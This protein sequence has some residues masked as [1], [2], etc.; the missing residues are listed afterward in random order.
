MV[1]GFRTKSF[2]YPFPTIIFSKGGKNIGISTYILIHL[3]RKIYNKRHGYVKLME[4]DLKDCIE[5][6]RPQNVVVSAVLCF[7]E[8]MV[9]TF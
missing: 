5:C 9:P 2:F 3:I 8:E 4:K 6:R 1:I 7:K